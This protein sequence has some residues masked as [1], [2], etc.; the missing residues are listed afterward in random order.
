M[1]TDAVLADL[2]AALEAERDTL[3]QQ[4]RDLGFGDGQTGPEYDSNFADSSQVTAERGEAEARAT[5]LREALDDV[6][7]ALAKFDEGT[8]G[9]CE[10]CGDQ[11][12]EARLEAMPSARYCI[13]CASK[14][15]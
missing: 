13:N 14:H 8:Y 3:A 9:Q 7:H 15:R 1:A 10:G 6:N 11:I 2:R 12:A 4:L 5:S